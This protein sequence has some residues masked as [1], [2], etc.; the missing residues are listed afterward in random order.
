MKYNAFN[1]L[2]DIN[3]LLLYGTCEESEYPYPT[4]EEIDHNINV[5]KEIDNMKNNIY[6]EKDLIN[7]SEK[8]K[9]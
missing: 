1:I 4:D 8:Y 6:S 5:I 7:I 9:N 2:E 3:T